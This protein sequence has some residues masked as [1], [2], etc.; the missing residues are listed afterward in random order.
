MQEPE[1]GITAILLL[2]PFLVVA[3]AYHIALETHSLNREKI[4]PDHLEQNFLLKKFTSLM[5]HQQATHYNAA[6]LVLSV[7]SCLQIL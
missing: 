6:Q 5:M 3:A 4:E 1:W 7:L 2:P